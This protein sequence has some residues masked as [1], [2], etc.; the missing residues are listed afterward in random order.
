LRIKRDNVA[1]AAAAAAEATTLKMHLGAFYS[2]PLSVNQSVNQSMNEFIDK[3]SN[4][5]EGSDRLH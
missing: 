2:N 4:A 3:L 1:A 5:H